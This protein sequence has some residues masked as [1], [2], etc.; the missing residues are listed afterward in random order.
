[1]TISFQQVSKRYRYEWIFKGIDFRFEPGRSYAI[2]G[3]NGSGKSTL[4]K[5]LCG[6]L[7]PSKGKVEFL[8]SEKKINS[9][10]V[11]QQVSYAAPY[12]ELIEEFTLKEALDFHQKFKPFRQDLGT[13][14]LMDLLAFS[15]A[16]NKEIRHFSS[17][18]KQRLKLALALCSDSPVLLLDEPTTNL[19][20]QGMD[21]YRQL[22]ERFAAGRLT[23][24][25]SNVEIDFDFCEEQ[26]DILKYKQ[27]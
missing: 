25:A 17:G 8:R 12:I 13:P 4:L 18:M 7:S 2:T 11:Y 24:V 23:V 3:P 27:F 26:V 10:E 15:K 1:M 6:H 16:A 19:D 20:R 21:W 9:D 5:I 14:E 22:V